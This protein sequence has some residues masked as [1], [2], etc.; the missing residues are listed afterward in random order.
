M[1]TSGA[2][3]K[4][5]VGIAEP[6]MNVIHGMHTDS[7]AGI[8]NLP[9]ALDQLTYGLREPSHASDVCLFFDLMQ[10]GIARSRAMQSVDRRQEERP[11]DHIDGACVPL[12]DQLRG[13][14]Q[15][16]AQK[17]VVRACERK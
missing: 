17:G 1:T 5:V 14:V 6:L 13:D 9:L 15:Y 8:L 12:F 3:G 11:G 7:I 2:M 16:Q 10:E 4:P